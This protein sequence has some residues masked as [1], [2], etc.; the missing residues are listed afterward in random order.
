M[1]LQHTCTFCIKVDKGKQDKTP[2]ALPLV[3]EKFQY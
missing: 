3:Q 1:V 2:K